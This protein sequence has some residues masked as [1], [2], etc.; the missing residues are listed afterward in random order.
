MNFLNFRLGKSLS[1]L[2]F[3]RT[4]LPSIVFLDGRGFVVVV[5]SFCTLNISSYLLLT[6][7]LCV[8]KSDNLMGIPLFV[9]S[10]FSLVLLSKSLSNFWYLIVV[11]LSMEFFLFFFPPL[12]FECLNLDIHFFFLFANFGKFSAIN[13]LNKLSVPFSSPSET[14]LMCLLL[15]SV[16]SH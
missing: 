14:L 2:Y 1:F 6:R 9:T 8:E 5:F 13:S 12:S 4:I 15:C 7:K 10:P 3:W 11:C 16:V